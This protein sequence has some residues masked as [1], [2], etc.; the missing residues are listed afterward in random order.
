MLF[1]VF[2][3][4]RK[5]KHKQEKRAEVYKTETRIAKKIHDEVANNV[6]NIM[7]KVQY[8]EEAKED[9]LDDLEKVYLLTRDISHQNKGIE[10]G[11]KYVESLKNLLTNFNS[12]TT[13]IILKNVNGIEL[14]KLSE[15]KQI[16][17]Y[18]VLQELMVNMQKHSKATL[19][20]LSF[21]KKKNSFSIQYSDN[22]VG[23]VLNTLEIKNSLSNVET[24][25]KSIN[26]MITFTTALNKGFKVFMTFK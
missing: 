7:N 25:I 23:V 19:V 3:Y 2:I 11:E 26:G 14:E 20:A 6:V 1:L 9:L 5:Q 15:I 16:E 24:R 13:T 17:I 10:T 4:I 8:T 18:R 21:E 22:G 12:N